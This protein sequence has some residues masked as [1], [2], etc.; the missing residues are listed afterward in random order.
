MGVNRRVSVGRGQWVR[1][2]RSVSFGGC[3]LLEVKCKVGSV[4]S[5]LKYT[6]GGQ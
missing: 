2:N 1:V 3:Q 6:S 4:R 5:D